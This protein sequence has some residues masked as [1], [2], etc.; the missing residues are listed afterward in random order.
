[1]ALC[2]DG[3]LLSVFVSCLCASLSFS[4]LL[5]L[6]KWSVKVE[7][8]ICYALP[9]SLFDFPCFHLF[10][11]NPWKFLAP[12][13]LSPV[14][15][16][17]SFSLKASK[18]SPILPQVDLCKNCASSP[19]P[20]LPFPW[21]QQNHKKSILNSLYLIPGLKSV[22]NSVISSLF[23][24]LLPSLTRREPSPVLVGLAT[25]LSMVWCGLESCLISA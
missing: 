23:Y 1:M 14:W 22:I 19:H 5:Q 10:M 20:K 18:Q 3:V 9:L 15:T 4:Y 16:I 24:Y 2:V 6:N 7:S 25:R 12:L 8:I 13:N 17:H 21:F 11:E